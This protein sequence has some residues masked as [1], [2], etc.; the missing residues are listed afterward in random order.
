MWRVRLIL[1]VSWLIASAVALGILPVGCRRQ[2]ALREAKP[3]DGATCD[4]DILWPP[5]DPELPRPSWIRPL[6]KGRLAIAAE[7]KGDG[8]SAAVRVAVTLT[9][10]AEEADRKYWNSALAYRY[11]DWMSEVRVW[12]AE[13]KWLWPNLPYLLRLPGRERVERYGGLD[14]SKFVD[15]DFAAVLVR[16]YGADGI[17][18]SAETKGSPMVSA[19]WHP[20]GVTTTDLHSVVHSATSDEFVV[21][22]G[23]KEKEGPARGRVKIWLIYADFLDS[24]PPRTWPSAREFAGGILAYLEIDWTTDFEGRC[25]GVASCKRPREST[26]F[27]WSAWVDRKLDSDRSEAKVRLSD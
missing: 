22:L 23:A 17:T 16:K 9:R 6:L 26:G 21:H 12:D 4:F 5:R 14:P 3:L 7:R 19:E 2:E 15:N 1:V 25:L 8:S 13:E 20:V 10:P 27:D 18:E 11:L 24:A